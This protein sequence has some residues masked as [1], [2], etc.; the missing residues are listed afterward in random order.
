MRTPSSKPVTRCLVM[1]ENADGESQVYDLTEVTLA[2]FEA[3]QPN[4]SGWVELRI[5]A[6]KTYDGKNTISL[7]SSWQSYFNEMSSHT[8]ELTD[9]INFGMKDN[10]TVENLRK[11][12]KKLRQKAEEVER[13]ARLAKLDHVASIR[14]Q[15]PIAVITATHPALAEVSTQPAKLA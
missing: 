5:Q 7:A 9:A 6:Q 13:E 15:H 3:S 11:R 14:G 8:A 12:A 10:L 2:A 1:L 4:Y